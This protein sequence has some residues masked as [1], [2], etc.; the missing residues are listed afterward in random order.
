MNFLQQQAYLILENKMHA[1]LGLIFLAEE[2]TQKWRRVGII[3]KCID[4]GNLI[5][6]VDFVIRKFHLLAQDMA[7]TPKC[8]M[9]NHVEDFR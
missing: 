9:Q 2:G 3:V 7:K 1:Q 5:A 6:S 4:V 8:R